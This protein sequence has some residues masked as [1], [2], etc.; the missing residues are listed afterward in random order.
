[1]TREEKTSAIAELK[2]EL[3]NVPFFYLTDSSTLSVAKINKLR[4]MCFERG[5]SMKV[6]KNTLIQKALESEPESKGYQA[7]Y[8]ALQGPTTILI[9][10]NPKAPA[11]LL[12]EFRKTEARPLLKA[13]YIDSSVYLGDEQLATLTK[14][15]SKEEMIGEI[16]GL[17]QSPAK[18]LASQITATGTKIAGIVKT[19]EERGA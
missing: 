10:S 5:I 16:I 13:A 14:L 19:L 9:S 4:R 12:E 7:I 11:Q 2:E 3:G 17:L 6:A 15:K 18:R 1:M 8:S